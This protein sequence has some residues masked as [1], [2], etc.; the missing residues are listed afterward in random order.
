LDR[1]FD[2]AD[3]RRVEDGNAAWLH[4]AEHCGLFDGE[5]VFLLSVATGTDDDPMPQWYR[6]RL[7]NAWDLIGAGA[8]DG[9]LGYGSLV[10]AFVMHSTDG[11]VLIAASTYESCF[12]VFAVPYPRRSEVLRRSAEYW[13]GR[14]DWPAERRQAARLWLSLNDDA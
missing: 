1:A 7:L 4:L 6:A 2:D 11:A 14:P 13:L 9:V 12:S 8:W 5:G 10:P 3:P